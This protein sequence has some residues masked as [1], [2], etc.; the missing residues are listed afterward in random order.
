M[1]NKS[2]P[3]VE[4]PPD[5]ALRGYFYTV[6]ADERGEHT[7]TGVWKNTDFLHLRDFALYLADLAPGRRVLDVGC[8]TGAMMVYCGLQGA[9]VYGQDLDAEHVAA[10]NE[11]LRRFGLTGEARCGDA[12]QLLFPDN[13]FDTVIAAD[14]FEHITDD[15]KGSSRNKLAKHARVAYPGRYE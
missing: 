3:Q 10:A 12:V 9:E 15:T 8:F 5:G 4:Y 1:S 14:F 2:H 6:P 11:A 7:P 13:H